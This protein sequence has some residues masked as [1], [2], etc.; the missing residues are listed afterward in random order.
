MNQTVLYIKMFIM[1]K[2]LRER[3]MYKK[4]WKIFKIGKNLMP[5]S[6]RCGQGKNTTD[7]WRLLNT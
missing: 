1:I 4:D 3:K 7:F 6:V 5:C 2:V